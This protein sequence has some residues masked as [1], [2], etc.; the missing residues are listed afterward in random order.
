MKRIALFFVLMTSLAISFAA[1]YLTED[2]ET[3][4]SGTPPAPAGW[5]QTSNKAIRSLTAE[6]DWL[7]N[8]W[9]GAAWSLPATYSP[10]TDPGAAQLGNSVLWI[11]DTGYMGNNTPE[12]SRRMESPAMNLLSSTSPYLRFWYFNAWGTASTLNVRAVVSGNG[13]ATWDLLTPI[14]NGFTG[15]INTWNSISVKIPAAYRTANCKIGFEIT[16][17]FVFNNPFID[18]VRVEDYTPPIITSTATGD[19]NVGT[20]WVGGNVPTAD[21]DVVIANGHTVTVTNSVSTTGIIARCQNLTVNGIMTQGAGLTNLLHAFGNISVGTT[22]ILRA[23]NGTV[24]R[25]VY[26]GGSFSIATG[27]SADFSVG[28]TKQNGISTTITY[29]APS[30]VFLGN[31]AASFTNAGTLVNGRIHNIMYLGQ[32][33]LVFNSPVT[34]PHTFGLYNG[35]VNPNGNLTLGNAP[36]AA[37]TQL[38][39]RSGN[40]FSSNPIWNNTNISKRDNYYYSPN[41]VPL[42]Q[43][44]LSTGNEIELIGGVRT[45]S[46]AFTMNTHNNLQLTYPLTLGITAV[47]GSWALTR[48]IVITDNV[49]QLW[50]TSF[51]STNPGTAP[52]I[53]TPPINHGSYIAGPLRRTFA[54]SGTTSRVFPLGVGT[55]FN[56]AVPNAN[57]IKNVTIV[58]AAAP[59]QANGQSPTVSIVG[60]P[61]GSFNSPLTALMT[62]RAYRV[63]LNGGTDFPAT[64]TITLNGMNYT[65]GNSD[66]LLGTE[67]DL[68]IAQSTS[69]SGPWTK[70]SV[71]LGGFVSFSNNTIY[72]RTSVASVAP[73]PI[74]PLGT[75][76][77]YFCWGSEDPTLPVELSSFTA[78][79]TD[80]L[81]VSLHWTSQSESGLS[82]Y[83]IYRN[84]SNNLQEAERINTLINPT[85]TSSEANYEF[86]DIEVASGNTY[87]YWLQNLDMNGTYGFHGPI[88]VFVND[89]GNI[90]PPPIITE[91]KLL[92]AY[93]NPFQQGTT[94]RYT[95][96]E[97]G[98]A[99]IEIYNVRGQLIHSF[100]TVHTDK[101]YKQIHW[102]GTDMNG[103]PVSSGVY[104]TKMTFGNYTASQKIVLVK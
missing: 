48:G 65:Y 98:L 85:N 9:T 103:N 20:T 73:G 31:E 12:N 95:V 99:R 53:L 89:G 68:R 3:A 45:V 34:V 63:N 5:T 25:T 22:G 91:T 69:L 1:T 24:G 70:R 30:L 35:T 81:Y 29:N 76:G 80:E 71:T 78:I 33:G 86:T 101:D 17:G 16:N 87:F 8:T 50:T 49:N 83:Y 62:P 28:T 54:N 84:T 100:S 59:D 32:N 4:F 7:Q 52:S 82:G 66:N 61:S 23:Y 15:T 102:D 79:L 2:F 19:W 26:C 93:P 96:K 11:D 77:E 13:G 57:V 40:S 39:V 41:W 43:T 46:G 74:A 90:T 6:K 10:T 21:N 51:I 37:T 18:N 75:Y 97:K 72:P 47:S 88:S 60:P 58:P 67:A 38:I 42:T 14:V 92:N 94:M 27:G 104:Y 36:V 56:G 55:A 64:A 44:T